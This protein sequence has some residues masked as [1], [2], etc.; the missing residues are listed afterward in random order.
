MLQ[1]QITLANHSLMLE[2]GTFKNHPT[3][4]KI[5]TYRTVSVWITGHV[6]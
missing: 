5:C 3:Q 1:S 2:A 4:K 6:W